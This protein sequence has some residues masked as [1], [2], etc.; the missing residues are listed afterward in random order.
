MLSVRLSFRIS[1]RLSE[2]TVRPDLCLYTF[3]RKIIMRYELVDNNVMPYTVRQPLAGI[4]YAYVAAGDRP[5][6]HH[7]EC[8]DETYPGDIEYSGMHMVFVAED[9]SAFFAYVK[10]HEGVFRIDN[11]TTMAQVLRR[12][13]N[14]DD[15]SDDFDGACYDHH[16]CEHYAEYGPRDDEDQFASP[17]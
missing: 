9:R 4:F 15:Y 7:V 13:N 3:T 2:A 11:V 12:L 16:G 6:L 5:T 1:A 14:R 8:D 10:S 17:R